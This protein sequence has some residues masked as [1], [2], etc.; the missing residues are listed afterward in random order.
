[1][2]DNYTFPFWDD[3]DYWQERS[4][5]DKNRKTIEDNYGD[6]SIIED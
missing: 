2:S 3:L 5:K 1:M 6:Q 4:R